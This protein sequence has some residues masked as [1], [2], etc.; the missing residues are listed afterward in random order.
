MGVEEGLLG[1]WRRG[2]R[3]KDVDDGLRVGGE[4]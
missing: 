4:G 1:G 2:D 3:G